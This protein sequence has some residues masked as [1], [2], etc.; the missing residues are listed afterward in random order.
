MNP[1]ELVLFDQFGGNWNAYV[2]EL[3]RIFSHDISSERLTFRGS[4]VGCRRVPVI[5][6]KLGAFWHVVQEGRIED[7]RTP[8]LRRCERIRWIGWVVENADKHPEIDVW[9]EIRDNKSDFLLW[10]REFYLVVLS[11][12]RDFWLLK[13]AYCTVQ[14]G[15]I[16][17]KRRERDA[18]RTKNCI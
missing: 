14:S 1:P 5:H 10:F 8:D 16:A 6:G 3:Y 7:E 17:Q 4:R 11:Q 9:E 13:T 15:R 18:F 2:D 12:R